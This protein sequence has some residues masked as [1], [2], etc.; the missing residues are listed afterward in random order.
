[1]LVVISEMMQTLRFDTME[2]ITEKALKRASETGL[3]Y[4]FTF[5]D[6]IFEASP[7]PEGYGRI[8]LIAE[9]PREEYTVGGNYNEFPWVDKGRSSWE[10]R[11][12][13]AEAEQDR[14]AAQYAAVEAAR[15]A[16]LAEEKAVKDA[17][18]GYATMKPRSAGTTASSIMQLSE[19]SAWKLTAAQEQMLANFVKTDS[20]IFQA[21]ESTANGLNV[22]TSNN[23]FWSSGEQL[24]WNAYPTYAGISRSE[25]PE[26]EVLRLRGL[27]RTVERVLGR[28]LREQLQAA[29]S[30]G[31]VYAQGPGYA[32]T[33]MEIRQVV[34]AL[35][36]VAGNPSP[37]WGTGLALGDLPADFTAESEDGEKI[38]LSKDGDRFDS[39]V[40]FDPANRPI[41]KFK[42]KELA[43]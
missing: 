34:Q 40:L 41:R 43:A 10:S 42:L 25:N 5:E 37:F 32:V 27:L 36:S 7:A 1:M 33:A 13:R 23:V 6:K 22:A 30:M 35:D 11:R 24:E 20:P 21:V 19:A 15:A 9:R 29:P 14:K 28:H 16:I 39:G 4:R 12:E 26:Q 8:T 18:R 31:S 2:S 38:V 17:Q 3:A